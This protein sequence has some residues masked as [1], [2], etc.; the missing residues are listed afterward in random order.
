[1]KEKRNSSSHFGS[2]HNRA[3]REAL[4]K[5]KI[6]EQQYLRAQQQEQNRRERE[7]F[8]RMRQEQ[9]HPSRN[10]QE[11]S[12]MR[13]DQ[14]VVRESQQKMRKL[15]KPLTA[16]QKYFRQLLWKTILILLIAGSI[17][18]LCLTVIF[19]VSYIS[20]EGNSKYSEEELIKACGIQMGSNLFRTDTSWPEQY[21]KE[22]F[23]YLEEV[24]VEKVLPSGIHI[25]VK[26]STAA[27]KVIIGNETLIVSSDG[28]ILEK[29]TTA[30]SVVTTDQTSSSQQGQTDD[31]TNGQTTDEEKDQTQQS[32]Q[33]SGQQDGQTTQEDSQDTTGQ[34][35]DEEQQ[36]DTTQQTEETQEFGAGLPR[37]TE[38]EGM[39]T[40]VGEYLFPEGDE[41]L[42]VHRSI[43][44]AL[45]SKDLISQVTRVNYSD[46]FDIRFIYQDRLMVVLGSRND[47][48][49]KIT[50]F[51][52]IQGQIYESQTGILTMTDTNQVPFTPKS[53]LD[54]AGWDAQHPLP[55]KETT[56]LGEEEE[57]EAE[58]SSDGEKTSS[59]D[60]KKDSST[61]TSSSSSGQS[62]TS[63]TSSSSGQSSTSSTSS[64]GGKTNSS[65]SSNTN[66]NKKS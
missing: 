60:D 6:Q 16:G 38:M 19:N 24:K 49:S 26:E 5:K 27:G 62:S 55:E 45:V 41:L 11:K 2:Y 20:V 23:P 61:S 8:L 56:T 37:I 21:L 52:E 50:R 39:N 66:G 29:Q 18:T 4:Q 30:S 12:A 14:P 17:I 43:M 15:K 10:H 25:T 28:R 1:M 48:E 54:L 40:E 59:S 33:T 7:E 46:Q 63:S 51:M 31:K 53:E 35:A 32:S 65:S 36:Q 42:E 57:T 47:L 44:Q 34:T 58:E 64:S 22:N 13:M 9:Y 3:Q